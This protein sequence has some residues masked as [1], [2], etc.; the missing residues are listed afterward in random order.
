M[1]EIGRGRFITKATTLTWSC[2]I[3]VTGNPRSMISCYMDLPISIG[4]KEFLA[5]TARKVVLFFMNNTNMFFI[6]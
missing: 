1:I 6:L 3:Y 5:F 2:G 4:I